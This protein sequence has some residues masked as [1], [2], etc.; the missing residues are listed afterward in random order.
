M[1]T[2]KLSVYLAGGQTIN[3][4][5]EVSDDLDDDEILTDLEADLTGNARPGWR[6]LG[7][8]IVFSQAVS[9]VDLD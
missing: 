9:A 1:N 5:I 6:C 4:E 2:R 7:S 3:T 8:A